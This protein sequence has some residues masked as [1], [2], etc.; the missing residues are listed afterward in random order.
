MIAAILN[1]FGSIIMWGLNQYI[2]IANL[3]EEQLKNYYAFLED[4]DNHTEID[5]KQYK[6]AAD[7]RQATKDRIRKRRLEEESK[8]DLP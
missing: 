3:K 6:E 8:P 4:I 5:A 1:I 2:K 7:A